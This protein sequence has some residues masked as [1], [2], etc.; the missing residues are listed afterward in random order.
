MGGGV[1]DCGG[2]GGGDCV[3]DEFGVGGVAAESTRVV[4]VVRVDGRGRRGEWREGCG[5]GVGDFVVGGGV[6]GDG[7]VCE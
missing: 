3:W 7:E 2:V 5:C 4:R 6:C 1:D